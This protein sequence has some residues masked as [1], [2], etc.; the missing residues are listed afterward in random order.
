MGMMIDGHWSHQEQLHENGAFVRAKSQLRCDPR[1]IGQLISDAPGRFHLIAS[2]SCPWSHRT[3]IARAIKGLQ[4]SVPV[5]FAFG[6]RPEGYAM[7]DGAPWPVPGAGKSIRNLHQ[8]YRLHDQTYTGRVTVPVLWDSREQKIISNE[9]AE[10][11]RGLD[12]VSNIHAEHEYTLYPAALQDEI[13][14]ANQQFYDQLNNGVYRAGFAKSQSAYEGAVKDVFAALDQLEARLA[15]QR[16]FFGNTITATDICLFPTL[17][18]F[19]A[20]YYIVFKCSRRRLVD[21]PNLWA[22]ARDLFQFP[23]IA[24]TIDFEAMRGASYAND[25]GENGNIVAVAPL[26]DWTAPPGPRTSWAGR[27]F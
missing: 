7:A 26:M 24:D 14:A 16:F 21:Y 11:M 18:R 3:T 4:R 9:S 25:S 20:I 15:G 10:I 23:G 6:R 22:Y 27:V 13:E 17:I 1:K 8:L 2:W 5:Y 19:D 12:F